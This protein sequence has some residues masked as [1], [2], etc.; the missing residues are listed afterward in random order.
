MDTEQLQ[1]ESIPSQTAYIPR[2][3]LR[4][5][6]RIIAHRLLAERTG[7]GVMGKDPLNTTETRENL[8]EDLIENKGEENG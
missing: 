3:V 4:P 8:N 2:E 1:P 6:A 7:E 5:L